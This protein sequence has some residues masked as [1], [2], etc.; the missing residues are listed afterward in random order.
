MNNR[1]PQIHLLRLVVAAVIVQAVGTGL[2]HA[3]LPSA[4]VRIWNTRPNLGRDP[5]ESVDDP[6][7]VTSQGTGVPTI[8]TLYE[9]T[10]HPGGP[11]GVAYWNPVSNFFKWYG[12]GLG[13]QSGID[14]NRAAPVKVHAPTGAV[15][16]PGDGWFAKSG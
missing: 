3:Q 16:G 4:E 8:V 2:A 13:F 10:T 12:F 7:G 6:A 5:T 9:N 15:F 11:C 1:K 14:I